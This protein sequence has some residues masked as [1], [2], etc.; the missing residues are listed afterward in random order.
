MNDH[1]DFLGEFSPVGQKTKLLLT[2]AGVPFE[3]VDAPPVLPR[4]DLENLG[5]TYRRI[6]VLAIGKDVYCDSS[7]IFDVVTK[8]LGKGKL[9]TTAAVS[10]HRDACRY[11]C[12]LTMAG[13]Q[14]KAWEAWGYDAFFDSL[15][16][17]GKSMNRRVAFPRRLGI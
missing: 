3:R 12:I 13:A 16:L 8:G 4:K 17:V 11:E 15:V 5:I 9:Q 14:D 10:F 7:L 2:A 6:P 1:T